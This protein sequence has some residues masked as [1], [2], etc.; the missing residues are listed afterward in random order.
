[1]KKQIVIYAILILIFLGYNFFFQ[2]KDERANTLINITF[3]SF[4]FL[5]IAYIAFVILKKIGKK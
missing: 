4:L 3:A 1:M 5:Y 2:V